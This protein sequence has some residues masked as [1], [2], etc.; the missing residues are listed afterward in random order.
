M[1][2][3]VL[4]KHV[5]RG[6]FVGVSVLFTPILLLVALFAPEAPPQMA[7][8]VLMVPVIAAFQG[9]IVGGLVMLG[10]TIWPIKQGKLE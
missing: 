10:V 2:K 4:F 7:F 3:G 1:D 8:G 5:W 6:W 9:G